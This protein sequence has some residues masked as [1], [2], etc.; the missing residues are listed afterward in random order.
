MSAKTGSEIPI[1]QGDIAKFFKSASMLLVSV[2]HAPKKDLAALR[3]D[4]APQMKA[5]G[6]MFGSGQA[7]PESRQSMAILKVAKELNQ[8]DDLFDE[9]VNV[10]LNAVRTGLQ[11][12][13]HIA[14]LYGKTSGLE[15]LQ[16]RRK[17]NELKLDAEIAEWTKKM[18]AQA[19]ITLFVAASYVTWKLSGLKAEE[20]SGVNVSFLGLPELVLGGQAQA[21]AGVLYHFGAYASTVQ[22]GLEFLKLTDMYFRA[23]LDDVKMQS[24]SFVESTADFTDKNYRLEGSAFTVSGFEAAASGGRRLVEFKPVY[25]KEI[26]GNVEAKRFTLRVA[27]FLM[28]YD[29]KRKMNPMMEFGAFPWMY[30]YSGEPGTGKTMLIKLAMSMVRDHCQVLDIPF[31]VHELPGD[32]IST[33]QGGSA[34]RFEQWWSVLRNPG[35]II[36]APIDDAE[37]IFTERSGENVSAGSKEVVASLL[38]CTEGATA[39]NR[40][41]VI[42]PWATNIPD[43]VDAAAMSRIMAKI[44]VPGAVTRNDFNDQMRMW[45]DGLQKLSPG[46]VDLAWPNDYRYLADQDISMVPDAQKRRR[47]ALVEF[48]DERLVRLYD[49]VRAQG[50]S[51]QSYDLHG[52]LF[53][54]IKKHMNRFTSREVRNI[55]TVVMSRLF[56]FDFPPEWLSDRAAFVEKD[57]DTKRAMILELAKVN[58]KGQKLSEILFEEMVRSVN[59]MVEIIDGGRTRRVRKMAEDLLER[60]EAQELAVR[61]KGGSK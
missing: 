19:A 11:I 34:E 3:S 21:T 61:M 15:A 16:A 2:S 24:K 38:R 43:M 4:S 55:T 13:F 44:P 26:V 57:Y 27:R 40:G 54:S 5:P 45:G 39:I 49:E 10:A 28:A 59:A 32:L 50:I 33:Y 41:N 18:E 1:T 35:E 53:A 47:D 22:S 36:V 37:N 14:Y 17:R 8:G 9:N 20:L 58:M 12:G 29:V 30:L 46:I 6:L 23:V 56:D 7:S 42:V 51:L 25:A 31:R 60:S 48:K 52:T